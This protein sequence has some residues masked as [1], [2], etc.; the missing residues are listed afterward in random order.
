MRK[1]ILTIIY[2]V[3]VTGVFAQKNDTVIY[4]LENSG[5]LLPTMYGADFKLVVSPPD[6]AVNKKLFVVNEYYSDGKLRLTGFSENKEA[7]LIFQGIQT[8][9]FRNGNKMKVRNFKDGNVAGDFTEYFPNGKIYNV[10]NYKKGKT[11]FFAE[12]KDSVGNELAQKGNRTWKEFLDGNFGNNYTIGEVK[13][14]VPV[15]TWHGVANDSLKF[16]SVYKNGAQVSFS[17]DDPEFARRKISVMKRYTSVEQVP[18][19]PGGLD[20]FTRYLEKNLIY[21]PLAKKNKT[22]G[23]VMVSFNVERDGK[24]T[25][26]QVAKGIGDGRDEE[27]LRVIS[28]SPKWKPGIQNGIPVRVSYSVP[29][30]FSLGN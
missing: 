29:I 25:N 18:E 14:G 22:Q 27:A 8:T 15:G 10:K 1:T 9:F 7:N 16:T 21:P 3:L 17:Y 4:Y 20:A 11:I 30:N 19:F 28:A 12:C 2:A 6:L 24:L 13:D 5:K 23:R 26:I